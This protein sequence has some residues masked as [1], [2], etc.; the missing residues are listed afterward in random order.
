MV[1]DL[2]GGAWTRKDRFAEKPMDRAVAASGVVVVAIDMTSPATLP[3]YTG[4]FRCLRCL[5]LNCVHD[6]LQLLGLC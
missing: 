5:S 2:H 3:R 1:P 4:W 6:L